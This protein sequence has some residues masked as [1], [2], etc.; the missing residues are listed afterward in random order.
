MNGIHTERMMVMKHMIVP[1][2][3]LAIVCLTAAMLAGCSDIRDGVPP[4][5]PP[6]QPIPG[7][8]YLFDLTNTGETY[9]I[10]LDAEI[11]LRL[12][13]NPT[14]GYSWQLTLTPG[15]VI[16]NESYQPD[17]PEGRLVGAGGTRLWIF[18]A[19]QPGMQT[20]SAFYARPW[21][22][23]VTEQTRFTL[24]LRA[25]VSP[26]QN[27]TLSPYTVYTEKDSCT[28]VRQDVGSEFEIRL[29]GNPTTGYSWNLTV[30]GGLSLTGEE[31]IPTYPAG[32]M[33][34]SGGIQVFSFTALQA[35]EQAIRGE[36][37]RP[38]VPSGTVTFIDLEGGFY[39]I[40]GDDGNRYLPL[41]LVPEY[42]VDGLRIAFEYE[43]EKDIA[44]VQMWGA[45]VNTTF[46]EKISRYDLIIRVQ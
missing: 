30:P 4:T 20:I 10:P 8:V 38:W 9:D 36:Y 41:N 32:R 37:R 15:L 42:Q 6:T 12:P 19:V 25:G 11:R 17:D 1:F 31:Y 33:T 29:A 13:E 40:I 14:T 43:P 39:G 21:E 46:I 23:S 3:I 16:E 2:L 22:S 5:P 45:P 7:E 44:T 27:S 26:V 35:G 34:G 24:N 28:T 18:K